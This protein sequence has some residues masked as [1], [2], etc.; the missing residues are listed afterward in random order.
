[1]SKDFAMVKKEGKKKSLNRKRPPT[2]VT[3]SG[4]AAVCSNQL[5]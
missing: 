2:E 3:D 4:W 1:M 5:G